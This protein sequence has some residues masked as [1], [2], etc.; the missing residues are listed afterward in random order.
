[1]LQR[2]ARLLSFRVRAPAVCRGARSLLHAWTS[3]PGVTCCLKHKGWMG[4]SIRHLSGELAQG[5]AM[6]EGAFH[7]LADTELEHL[8]DTVEGALE[9]AGM[10]E[11]EVNLAMG[12]LT[13][14]VEG[15]GTWVLNKQTP[16]RQIWWSSPL[17]GPKRYEYNHDAK[18]WVNSRDRSPMESLLTEEMKEECGVEL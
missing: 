14:A 10:E 18:Q 6:S 8:Q 5:V 12:V 4:L 7:D 1:M 2:Q 15:H 11:F 16:N 3:Q 17:S 9:A 13:I